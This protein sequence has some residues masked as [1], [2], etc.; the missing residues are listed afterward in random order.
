[1]SFAGFFPALALL[2]GHV[3]TASAF[4]AAIAVALIV[5]AGTLRVL[6]GLARPVRRLGNLLG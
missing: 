5:Q 3:S 4:G 6:G 2:L 1:L